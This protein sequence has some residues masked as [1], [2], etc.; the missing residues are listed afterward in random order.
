MKKYFSL[1]LVWA[2]CF[3]ACNGKNSEEQNE[4]SAEDSVEQQESFA[5][6]FSATLT[7]A[8]QGEVKTKSLP[9]LRRGSR[10]AG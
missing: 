8:E 6:D 3:V 2:M 4:K 9:R 7:K 1:L 5:D 10:P